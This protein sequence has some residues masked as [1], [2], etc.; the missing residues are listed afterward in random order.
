MSLL[1][2]ALS[3]QYVD[4]PVSDFLKSNIEISNAR[5]CHKKKKRNSLENNNPHMCW[6]HHGTKVG[7][8][9]V[10]LRSSSAHA[11]KIQSTR[12]DERDATGK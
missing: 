4:T 12:A 11:L 2:I 6:Q 7:S 1:Y 9:A 5:Y 8:R 10:T 3:Q